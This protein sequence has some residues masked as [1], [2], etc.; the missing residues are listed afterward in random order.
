MYHMK[1]RLE[2][3]SGPFKDRPSCQ[4]YEQWILS[5]GK[6]I[7]G[8]KKKEITARR[9]GN[10]TAG[11]TSGTD[12]AT[13]SAYTTPSTSRFTKLAGPGTVDST[14]NSANNSR[15]TKLSNH[16][17]N[18]FAEIFAENDDLIWP[19]QLVDSRDKEQFKVLFPLLYKLPHT[20]MYYLDELIFPEVLQ[21]QNLKL[22]TC[23]MLYAVYMLYC[24]LVCICMCL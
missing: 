16:S 12:T 9:L 1:E 19:L 8:S 21:Y 24:V 6:K 4:Q 7:R 11:T 14:N 17:I 18:I 22:S 5:A 23:G 15:Y 3:E 2:E 13:N 20:V 10:G